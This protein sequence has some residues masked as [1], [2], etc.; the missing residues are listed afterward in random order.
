MIS[1]SNFDTGYG[2]I[3]YDLYYKIL[4]RLVLKIMEKCSIMSIKDNYKLSEVM[5]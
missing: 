4:C 1:V 2:Y 5:E 3:K